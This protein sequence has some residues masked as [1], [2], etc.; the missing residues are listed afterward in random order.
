MH[1]AR[2]FVVWW[3]VLL[4]LWMM[5]VSDTDWSYLFVGIGC[6]A[7]SALAALLAHSTLQQHYATDVRWL[8]WFLTAV[9]SSVAD[10]V[11][12]TRLMVRPASERAAGRLR[13][14]TLPS[15][16]PRRSAGRRATA[17]IALGL[18]PGSYVVD[19]VDDRL[20]LHELP[21]SSRALPDQVCR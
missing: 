17:V 19:V 4:A 5:L 13:E 15:E 7:L 8:R 14:L 9:P 2:R 12:L 1:A 3:V 11:R 10:T 20:L 16:G 18:A 21:G 6:S